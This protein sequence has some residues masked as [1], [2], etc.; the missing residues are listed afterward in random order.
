[1]K[2]ILYAGIMG[3]GLLAARP[4]QAC[5][6]SGE[7]AYLRR[8]ERTGKEEPSPRSLTTSPTNLEQLL[9]SSAECNS[10][11]ISSEGRVDCSYERLIGGCGNDRLVSRKVHEYDFNRVKRVKVTGSTVRVFVPGEDAVYTFSDESTAQ[12]AATLLN[13]YRKNPPQPEKTEMPMRFEP[14]GGYKY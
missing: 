4:A 1:M 10:V 11:S 3:L 12:Q 8:I 13:Q 14:K 5:N 9:R 7:D 2:N 6:G